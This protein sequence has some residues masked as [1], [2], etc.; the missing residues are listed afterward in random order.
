MNTENITRVRRLDLDTVLYSGSAY[1]SQGSSAAG[2]WIIVYM[3]DLCFRIFLHEIDFIFH[4]ILLSQQFIDIYIYTY[5][6]NYMYIPLDTIATLTFLCS[7]DIGIN[8]QNN[9]ET[10]IRI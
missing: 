6:Y 4:V 2:H 1:Q 10:I 7:F 9:G 8:V 5:M 3:E